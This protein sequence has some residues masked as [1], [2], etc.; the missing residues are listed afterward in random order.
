MANS[1]HIEW[2]DATWNPI[3]G[4]SKISPGCKFCYA[5]RLSRRL[6]AMGQENYRNGF[7]VTLQ[8]HML[9]HPLR[10][11]QPRRVFVNSMSDL[12]HD[13]VPVA[14]IQQIF[15]VMRRASW[16]QF[17]VLTKRSERLLELDPVLEW[18]RQIWMGVSVE[19]EDYLYRIDHLRRTSAVIKFLS[20]EPLLGPLRK[21]KLRGIDWVIVGGE[22]GPGAR[23]IDPEWVREIRDRCISARVA[24]FFKQWGGVLK[25]KT[26]RTLDGRKWDELPT[27]GPAIA[28]TMEDKAFV[29]LA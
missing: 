27:Y 10:W 23:P 25:S 1:S 5:E 22:S 26:G 15:D 20:I 14:Y 16:H 2:T 21:L 18:Q 9:E 4:C 3:T 11:R 12:F 13:D 19:N 24:F 29:V 6:Q 7:E 8:P 28:P 17:Q